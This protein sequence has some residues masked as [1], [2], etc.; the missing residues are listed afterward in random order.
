MKGMG[1]TMRKVLTRKVQFEFLASE[2]QDVYST[3][4]F[5]NWHSSANR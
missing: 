3:G 2:A 4:N 5:N 1:K